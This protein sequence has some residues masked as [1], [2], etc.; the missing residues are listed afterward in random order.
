MKVDKIKI[1][2]ISLPKKSFKWTEEN[3]AHN[4]LYIDLS[5]VDRITKTITE[6]LV[7]NASN[8]PSRA[9][10]L[11]STGDILF[12]TTRPLLKRSCIVDEKYDGQLCSTGFCVIRPNK[13]KVNTKWL[14]FALCANRFYEYIKPL[15][16]GISYPAVS[17]KDVYN[18]ILSFPSLAEQQVIASELDA[19]QAMI[20]GY[21]AQ[22][23]DLD[24]LAQSIFLDMFGDPITNP[25]GWEIER[26]ENVFL[27]RTGKLDSNSMEEDGVYPFFTCSKDILRINT[28]AFDCE[29]LLLAGNNAS[30]NYDVKYYRGK[31]NAYQRT[32]VLTLKNKDF[33]YHIFKFQLE[34]RLLQLKN[35]SLGSSTKYLT[36]KILNKLNFI[37]PPLSLQK[38]FATQVETIEQQKELFRQQLADAESLMAERM[39]YYFS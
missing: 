18:Y 1:G 16:R 37:I 10:Q 15:Q 8:A 6:H 3:S 9:K 33:I 14:H 38:H 30:G 29:A 32:Y 24:A 22:I 39:Q 27:T 36:L 11:V 17:D 31:F 21:K 7:V 28:Y 2:D 12:G 13:N 20:D 25:K 19:V 34:N 35:A 23:A 26:W 4:Y 5:S